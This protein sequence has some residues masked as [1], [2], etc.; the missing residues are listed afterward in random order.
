MMWAMSS[1]EGHG[2]AVLGWAS[3]A[4]S[5]ISM[6]VRSHP[7]SRD[8]SSVVVMTAIGVASASMNSMRAAG[9]HR[10]DRQIRRPGLEHRQDRHNRLGGP[11]KQQRDAHTRARTM[12]S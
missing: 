8:R 3:T 2:N 1:G 11:G 12:F 7:S 4:G 6:T 10:V 9:M 5:V